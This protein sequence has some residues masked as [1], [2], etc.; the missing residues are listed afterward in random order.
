MSNDGVIVRFAKWVA[1]ITAVLIATLPPLTFFLVS[2]AMSVGELEQQVRFAS[3]DITRV[4]NRSPQAWRFE[5]IRLEQILRNP[6][7]LDVGNGDPLD[8]GLDRDSEAWRLTSAEGAV[9]AA[10]HSSPDGRLPWPVVRREQTV[11]DFGRVVGKVVVERSLRGLVLR[12]SV[13][14]LASLGVSVIVFFSLSV[15]PLRAM[16]RAWTQVSYLASHDPLTGLANRAVFRDRL[17]HALRVAHRYEETVAV[18]CLDLDRFKD[19]ND[20]LGHAVGD[21]LLKE[22]G[23]RLQAEIRESDTVARLSGD[24][25]AIIQVRLDQPEHAA[26]LAGRIIARIGKPFQINGHR[27]GVGVSIGI[28]VATSSLEAN[29]TELLKNADLALYA[30]KQR[31]RGGYSFYHEDMNAR[32]QMRRLI[33][34]ELHAAL[35]QRSFEIYYQPQIDLEDHSII[36]VEALLRW[37]HPTRGF[38][39]PSE[40]IPVAEECGAILALSEWVLRKACSDATRWQNLRV[41]VNLSPIQFRTH[42]LVELVKRTLEETR[43]DPTRLELEI[44]EGI[45]MKDTKDNIAT[46]N[47]LKALGVR[48]AM[49]DFGTG[50]SSLSYLS[51]FPFD[52]IKIDRSFISHAAKSADGVSIIRAAIGMSRSLKID[53]SVEGVETQEQVDLLWHEGCRE[54]QGYFFGKPMPIAEFDGVFLK[55]LTAQGGRLDR[56]Q[57]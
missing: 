20:V 16:R 39:P 3:Q 34:N 48:I 38:I 53:A 8:I 55:S 9:I 41:A 5:V 12:A 40:F 29:A 1:A 42:G 47:K 33:E 17:D 44:T 52:K 43:L 11:S 19:V 25:F 54:V 35:E 22:V 18:L 14:A 46:L 51:K 50:Y 21:L 31:G 45:L 15:F 10:F 37:P 13:V 28:A 27:L 4:I 23:A 26:S 2:A 32:L 36:G 6:Y 24:E 56:V 49:D 7:Q 57:A 30:S